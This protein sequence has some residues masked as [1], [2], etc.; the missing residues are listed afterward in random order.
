LLEVQ[1]TW[2]YR[3]DG[4][5][6]PMARISMVVDDLLFYG[7]SILVTAR[8]LDGQITE[9]EWL[10]F[11]RWKFVEDVLL[12]D[13]E[14]VSEDAYVHVYVPGYAGLL[15]VGSRSLKAGRDLENDVARRAATPLP[16]TIIRQTEQVQL[17]PQEVTDLIAA[18]RNARKDPNGAVAFV[19]YGLDVQTFSSSDQ[20]MLLEAR[21]ALVT[22]V[23]QLTNVRASMLDGTSSIDSL[24]YVTAQGERNSFVDFDLPFWTSPIE[25]ALSAAVPRGQRVRFDLSEF[26]ANPP[27]STGAVTD[28]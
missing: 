27:T 6:T 11:D 17:E 18:Y 4:A 2:L 26:A 21:N 28:D 14:P 5:Q 13:D 1:P 19:P 3:D 12:I 20:P 24:T 7:Q 10:A 22:T 15:S 8:G 16:A 23:G 9:A 25:A